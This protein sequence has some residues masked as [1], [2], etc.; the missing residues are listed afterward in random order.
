[1]Y[2]VDIE[3]SSM[4]LEGSALDNCICR[5]SCSLEKMTCV[6]LAVGRREQGQEDGQAPLPVSKR[7]GDLVLYHVGI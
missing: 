1:M 3:A 4:R 7:E 2:R 6:N 5:T